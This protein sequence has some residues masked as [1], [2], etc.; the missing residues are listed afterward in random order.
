MPGIFADLYGIVE[1][2]SNECEEGSYT[3]YLLDSGIDKILKKLGEETAE[4]I[5]AAK[6][7]AHGSSVKDNP[8]GDAIALGNAMDCKIVSPGA[9][10]AD[11]G[12]AASGDE[13]EALKNEVADLLYH[14]VVMLFELNIS[15]DEIEDLLRMRMQKTGNLK[16]P[17]QTN[18]DT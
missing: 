3:A 2:R 8:E 14:L 9:G 17:H 18:K 13:R 1:K 4:T 5:I 6:N 11:A 16:S 12:D 7:L 10:T 15:P